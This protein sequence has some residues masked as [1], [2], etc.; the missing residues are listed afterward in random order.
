M[1]LNYTSNFQAF[2]VFVW[3]TLSDYFLLTNKF[4][5]LML[6]QSILTEFFRKAD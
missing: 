3:C 5:F 6:S 4:D 2:W 1:K